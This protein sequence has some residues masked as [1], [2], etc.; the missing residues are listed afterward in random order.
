MNYKVQGYQSDGS[1]ENGNSDSIENHYEI[2]ATQDE[3]IEFIEEMHEER[4]VEY[5]HATI[6]KTEG[7]VT[8]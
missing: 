3:A 5:L 4:A 6:E 1:G 2:F 8:A 7:S